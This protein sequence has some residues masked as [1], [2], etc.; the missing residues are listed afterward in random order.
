MATQYIECPTA[1]QARLISLAFFGLSRPAKVAI[2]NGDTTLFLWRIFPHPTL[3]KAL[4]ELDPVANIYLHPQADLFTC[5][6]TALDTSPPTPAEI[7]AYQA[8]NADVVAAGGMTVQVSSI[9]P[10][11]VPLLSSGVVLAA[12]YI[13]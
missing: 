13:L 10:A 5:L 12:G 2:A 8:L 3:N 9:L 11:A 7:L 6:K 4:L 1:D